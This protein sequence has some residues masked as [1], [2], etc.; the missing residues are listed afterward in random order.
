MA[1]STAVDISAVARVL[2]IKTNFKKF[3]GWSRGDFAAADRFSWSRCVE[4][5]F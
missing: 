1:I 4:Y 5:G 3:A 2:G